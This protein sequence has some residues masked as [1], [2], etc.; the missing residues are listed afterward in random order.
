VKRVLVKCFVPSMDPSVNQW[1]TTDRPD[2]SSSGDATVHVIGW[3][4]G[5]YKDKIF[6]K[7]NSIKMK[8]SIEKN[9]KNLKNSKKNF[10]KISKNPI[11]IYIISHGWVQ[12]CANGRVG[13]RYGV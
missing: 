8:N 6:K 13:G 11:T 2:T 9:E 10:K 5:S 1:Q 7:K 4:N 3:Y 12:P